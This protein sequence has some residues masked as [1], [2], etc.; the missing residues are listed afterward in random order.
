MSDENENGRP[1]GRTPMTLKPRQGSVSAGVVKQ[2]FSHGRTKTVVVETKRTRTHAPASGNLAAPSSAERRHGEAPAPRP[3]PPQGGGGGSAGGLSQEE[4]R[5]RQRVVDAAREAQARQVAEQAAA[6]ARARAAQEAAQREAAAKAAAERAAAAPPPVAQAP[7]APAPAAP[8]TPPPAAPQAPRP[9]AQAPVAPSAPRQD[10]PRQDTRAAAPG[11]TRTYEPSRDRRDDRPSTTTYRPAPQG[12]RPFN[13]RAPRPDAN[14]NFGQRAPRPEGD[15]PRGPRPDG[16]RPQGDRGGYRGDRP[17]GDRPQGDR[18]QQTVRYSALA[19]RPAPGARGPGG[20][21]RGPRPG[22]PA[23]APATPEIQRA[24]RSAPRPGGGAMDRRPDEDDDRRKNAAP[25]KAVSRVKGAPQRREGRLTIQAVAG[26]GDSADRMRSLAS[27]RRAREREK[28]KRRGGA[29]EQARVAREV[30]IP[31]VITVQ[32]LSNR[33]A[34]RG[35]DIIKFLMR[36]GVMLKIN[37]VIDNDTAELVAT[38]FGHTVKRVSEADVEEGFI[39]ADDHDE[40]MD[41]RPPVVTI[42]GHV[43]HGKT[44]LLDALRSTDVAAGEAGGITQH[45]GAYQVRLKDGQRVT[46]LDTPGHAAFSSMRARG[47]NITD[48]VVLVVAGDDGVMPQTIEAIKHA[49]AA[50]VPIIVAVNKM[51][52]P[53]SDPTRVVNELLQHEIVVESLGGDTQLIEV[54]AKAR[55]GLDNLLEAILLQAEVLDLKA[56]PDRSADGVVIEAKLDKGRGAVSTVLVNRGTLKRGDIVVAGSQWGKVRALLNERNEQLQ[57]AGPATPVEILG[58]DGVPSP[59]DAFA[60]VENEA[61]ARELTE[62]RIRLKR[63]KSMAPVGAGASMADMMAK[64]QD[65]KLK[66]LPL[67]IKA[68]VQGSAEAIIGSLDK[69]ATDEVRARIILSGAGAISESDVMLAK[70]AGAPVIGFNVRASA[71]ARALAEREGVEIRYYAIIYDLLDDIKGVL[72]GMLAPIQRETFLGNAEVLQA[73]DISKIGKV[74]GCKVTEGVVRK[75]AKVRIIRQ[76]IVVLELGTL[77]TLKRFKDEVN[78][79]PVGQECGMMFA[80]FQDIKVGDTIECF[81]VEEIKRQLD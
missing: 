26:D 50:E 22:V 19:P 15:R 77:Q 73:F 14:A 31:D 9:V 65:K 4:L 52:K 78:E 56:N 37:D 2:S 54:S 7:A 68:D 53:G 63:E 59:G 79:V 45:I 18:P 44:S 17:Q 34:V 58:L 1:G 51:D 66:E 43:D 10:A 35:V 57:E 36:Q 38:E 81:T 23:A 20:P 49:K 42:M 16:D 60:V 72:S 33:M 27:V 55:T 39:G 70:G 8:V 25:N 62:Y 30:V 32:E 40:H 24:T 48:I 46:F 3:A 6:E 21:P 74:A 61:R 41:L 71:Q 28:E 47:A 80:G 13:Q 5:A 75:G 11:Q 69:M 76:D 67:V 64:L 29:V 12:D